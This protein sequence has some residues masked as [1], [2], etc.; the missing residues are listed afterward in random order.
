[1]KKI[2]NKRL[3]ARIMWSTVFIVLLQ[4]AIFM[5]V[6][7]ATRTLGKLDESTVKILQNMVETRSSDFED[8]MLLWTDLGYFNESVTRQMGSIAEKTGVPISLAVQDSEERRHFLNNIFPTVLETLRVRNVT[9]CFIILDNEKNNMEA[10]FLRDLDPDEDSAENS[11]VI[12]VAGSSDLM[13]KRGLTLDKLWTEK[14]EMTDDAY[15]IYRESLEAGNEYPEMTGQNLGHYSLPVRF[16]ENDLEIVTYMIPL[17]DENHHSIGVVG[18]GLSVDYMRNRLDSSEIGIDDEACYYVGIQESSNELHTVIAESGRF[19]SRFPSGSF[20]QLEGEDPA[21]GLNMVAGEDA[22]IYSQDMRFYNTNTPFEKQKWVL[23]AIVQRS[24]LTA[25]S[26]ALFTALLAAVAV[27][28]AMSIWSAYGL[29]NVMTKPLNMLMQGA[30][31]ITS[32]HVALPRTSIYEIDELA[33]AVEKQSEKVIREGAK[34]ADIIGMSNLKLG[35]L[36]YDR[37]SGMVFLTGDFVDM[38]ELPREVFKENYVD[39]E[40]VHKHMQEV[41]QRVEQAEEEENIFCISRRDGTKTYMQVI[42]KDTARE[43]MCI[44]QDITDAMKEK[45]K[46]RHDRDYDMLTDLYNRRAFCRIVN[47]L[48]E[49]KSVKEGIM[50]VW[51]LDHLKYVNDS[52]GHDMGDQYICLVA[53]VLK[54]YT[55]EQFCAAR[56]SGDEYVVFVYGQPLEQLKELVASLHKKFLSQRLQLTD[57]SH[58]M[59][60]AS[61]GTAVYPRDGDYYDRMLK[62]A[63]FAMYESKRKSKGSIREFDEENYRRDSILMR[64]VGEL[65]RIIRERSI[66]YAYQPIIS[67]KDRTVFAFEA[68]MRPL[69]DMIKNPADF[70]RISESQSKLGQVER[71]TWQCSIPDFFYHKGAPDSVYLFLNSIPSQCLTDGEFEEINRICGSKL[72][73]VVVELTENARA[74]KKLEER[75]NQFCKTHGMRFALDDF[76]AGY[77]NSDVLMNRGFDFVKLDISIIRNIHTDKT[78]QEYVRGVI[79]YCHSNGLK[80]ISEGIE[81]KEELAEVM[82]LGTDYV[83]GFYFSK[84]EF[85]LGRLDYTEF[86]D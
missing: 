22:C 13:F 47:R 84:P 67:A 50:A 18:V 55:G 54:D 16:R 30:R 59:L 80:V 42:R 51:D 6:I 41:R 58:V 19:K 28:I 32:G 52:Y 86:F 44:C 26:T 71:L 10:L 14:L 64:G 12:V 68:L 20:L 40:L 78:A 69:S 33:E 61:G 75:K 45:Q 82:A 31:N 27:S 11:D 56:M 46:I 8:Q 49:S 79:Q 83:Q 65:N 85:E 24:A 35:I 66:R 63:D 21:T 70:L 9:D 29:T 81:T 73:R 39:I 2:R 62:C 1:M 57:G 74:E 34:V 17:L 38:F 72:D 37:D 76:G 60:S 36:E 77:S 15:K 23:G 53:D 5:G 7:A 48:M 43:V 4:A 3:K 25:S